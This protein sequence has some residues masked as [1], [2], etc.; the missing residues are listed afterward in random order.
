V[1]QSTSSLKTLITSLSQFFTTEL[2]F[3]YTFV[4]FA[5]TFN[6]S[7]G[8]GKINLDQENQPI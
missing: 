3:F 4:P 8:H 5:R 7:K 1:E 6:Q 2:L